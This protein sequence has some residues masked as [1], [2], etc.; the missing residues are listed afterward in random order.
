M[1]FL[2]KYMEKN[3]FGKLLCA[4]GL[5]LQKITTKEPN[6]EQLEVAFES[7]KS[8]FGDKYD[9]VKGGKYKADAIG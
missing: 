5:L 8:A 3:Y 4:P 2:A 7:L 1:K 9:Q 6:R